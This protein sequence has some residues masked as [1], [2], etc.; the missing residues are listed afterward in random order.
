MASIARMRRYSE[1]A[2]VYLDEGTETPDNALKLGET[3]GVAAGLA[4]TINGSAVVTLDSGHGITND[5]IVC[6]TWVGGYRYNCTV[7]NAG[8]TA[9]TIG[10]GAGSTLP[11]SGAVAVSVKTV[12]TQTWDGTKTTLI[13][14]SCSVA[15]I[16][17]IEDGSTVHLA[18]S[19]AAGGA[20]IW[21]SIDGTASPIDSDTPTKL[22]VYNCST[23]SGVAKILIG[24]SN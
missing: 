17:T 9:I 22:H 23:T 15:A 12:I 4:G 7:S 20:Y 21:D 6:V 5:S 16:I 13:I 19:V 3:A 24:V 8:A 14:L 11:T 18:A 1:G 2:D 10:G